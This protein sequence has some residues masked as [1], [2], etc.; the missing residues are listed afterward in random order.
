[1]CYGWSALGNVSN[2]SKTNL[3]P[4]Y[5]IAEIQ[6]RFSNLFQTSSRRMVCHNTEAQSQNYVMMS[7]VEFN[8]MSQ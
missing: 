5:E 6:S 4:Y 8:N 2:A 3:G 7:I 1:M